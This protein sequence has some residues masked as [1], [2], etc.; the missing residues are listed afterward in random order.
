MHKSFF[1]L[2]DAYYPAALVIVKVARDTKEN[3]VQGGIIR[4]DS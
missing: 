3:E 2:R 1:I 4:L